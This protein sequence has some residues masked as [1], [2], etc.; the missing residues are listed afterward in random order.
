MG[1]GNSDELVGGGAALVPWFG[2][3]VVAIGMAGAAIALRH[4]LRFAHRALAGAGV[5]LVAWFVVA[6]VV[7]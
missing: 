3:P 4:R 2:L 1:P 5:C 7:S 6:G